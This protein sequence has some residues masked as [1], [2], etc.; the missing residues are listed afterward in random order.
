MSSPVPKKG[1]REP[2]PT[3]KQAAFLAAYAELG[4]IT[5]ACKIAG[6]SP[7]SVPPWKWE[8]EFSVSFAAAHEQA[9]DKL[10]ME[11]RRRAVEGTDEPVFYKGEKC[12]DV[13][14]YSDNLLMFILK[15]ARPEKYAERQKV[16]VTEGVLTDAQLERIASGEQPSAELVPSTGGGGVAQAE[17]VEE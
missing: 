15:G 2:R 16:E 7:A 12:G 4:I 9:I 8:P 10:E 14:K 1:E 6:C 11:A 3:L 5:A 17:T 13:R